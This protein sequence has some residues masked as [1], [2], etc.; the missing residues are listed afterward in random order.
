MWSKPRVIFDPGVNN[1]TIGNQIVVDPRTGT[2]YNFFTYEQPSNDLVP[3]GT[4]IKRQILVQRSVALLRWS[5]CVQGTKGRL[6]ARSRMET[7]GS[8]CKSRP[9]SRSRLVGFPSNKDEATA[10]AVA[11]SLFVT[12]PPRHALSRPPVASPCRV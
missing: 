7:L 1:R 5:F 8:Y 11:S 9:C 12:L 2:L 3:P 10:T 4:P 6:S